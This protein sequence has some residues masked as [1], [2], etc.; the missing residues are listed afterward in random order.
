MITAF[1]VAFFIFVGVCLAEFAALLFN[2]HIRRKEKKRGK[3]EQ[4]QG[5]ENYEFEEDVHIDWI[6]IADWPDRHNDRTRSV[7]HCQIGRNDRKD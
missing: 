6:N 3:L 2:W 5:G 7:K 1:I 4:E